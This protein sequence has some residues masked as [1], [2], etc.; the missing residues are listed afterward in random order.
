MKIT[1]KLIKII[2]IK[3]L[4]EAQ[5]WNEINPAKPPPPTHL[6][7]TATTGTS[8]GTGASSSNKQQQP[9]QAAIYSEMSDYIHSLK[10][11][12]NS[13]I[14]EL[15]DQYSNMHHDAQLLL[16]P[17]TPPQSQCEI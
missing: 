4:V 8:T 3:L 10:K 7:P 11:L 15:I 13:K 14:N 1:K 16:P 9:V 12:K 6:I 2:R 5:K 17:A